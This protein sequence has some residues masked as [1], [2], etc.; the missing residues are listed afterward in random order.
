V[1]TSLQNPW[2]AELLSLGRRK[3][4]RGAAVTGEVLGIGGFGLEDDAPQ[5]VPPPAVV[6][7][8]RPRARRRRRSPLLQFCSA[9]Q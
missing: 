8:L 3:F 2:A 7:P 6:E 9:S 1:R 4:L 5:P